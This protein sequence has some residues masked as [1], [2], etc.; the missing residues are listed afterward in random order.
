MK[1]LISAISPKNTELLGD[2]DMFNH[3]LHSFNHEAGNSLTAL[4]STGSVLEQMEDEKVRL[5]GATVVN[6]AW[7]LSRLQEFF[8]LSC[9]S[10]EPALS[11]HQLPEL[12][13]KIVKRAS[14]RRLLSGLKINYTPPDSELA[15]QTDS[16]Q[17]R[18]L[19]NELLRNAY[20]HLHK[21]PEV[22]TEADLKVEH[23]DTGAKLT[24][25]N[26][27]L[28]DV[29][30]SLEDMFAPFHKGETSSNGPGLGLTMVSTICKRLSIDLSINI[31]KLDEN[32]YFI[33]EVLLPT[34]ASC[35]ASTTWDKP[36]Q[37][38]TKLT[39]HRVLIADDED[40]IRSAI[41]KLLQVA[42]REEEFEVVDS[43]GEDVNDLLASS[44][45][46]DL[47]LLDINL[48]SQNGFEVYQKLIENKPE[49]RDSVV[50]LSGARGDTDIEGQIK[51]LG[52]KCLYKPFEIGELIEVVGSVIGENT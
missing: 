9:S 49:V 8:V 39:K 33:A 20:F 38:F 37:Q 46:F 2:A 17:M 1:R 21:R 28:G 13:D 48:R 4:I 18:L 50:F 40:S 32:K 35:E 7:R 6:E 3:L 52:A 11:N 44:T 24:V 34:V 29:P 41:S 45:N 23:C 5:F 10:R 42:F 16:E 19:I 43:S 36:T 30:P 15:I 22:T 25:K 27:F 51:E 14:F 12:V 31:T 26:L 47:I